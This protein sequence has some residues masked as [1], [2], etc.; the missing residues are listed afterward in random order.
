MEDRN[1]PWGKKKVDEGKVSKLIENLI[2]SNIV[3]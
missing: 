1:E 2:G 3:Q